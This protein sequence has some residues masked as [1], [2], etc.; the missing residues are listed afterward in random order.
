[1]CNLLKVSTI[2]FSNPSTFT[3]CYDKMFCL[4]FYPDF[5]DDINCITN[6]KG[7]LKSSSPHEKILN[8]AQI[9][10]NDL[11]II[12]LMP[13]CWLEQWHYLQVPDF[14]PGNQVVFGTT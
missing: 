3:V 6:V 1:M 5:P 9:R 14:V 8:R 13:S 4:L 2:L 7:S 12:V 10:C 11:Q